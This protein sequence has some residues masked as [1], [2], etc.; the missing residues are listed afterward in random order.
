MKRLLMVFSVLVLAF[1]LS[2]CSEDK[3]KI[4]VLNWGDYVDYDII[5]A[6]EEEYDVKVVYEEVDKDDNKKSENKEIEKTFV[7]KTGMTTLEFFKT[8]EAQ[9]IESQNPKGIEIVPEASKTAEDFIALST[10]ALK[11]RVEY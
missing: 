5:D 8:L 6:F 3:T 4:Y 1:A 10:E 9:L 7:E 11:I 2:G